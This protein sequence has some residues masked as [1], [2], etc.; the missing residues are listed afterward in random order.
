[1]TIEDPIE[2]K[3]NGINQMQVNLKAG[4]DFAKGLRAIL[5]QDP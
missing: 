1:M 5:R 2:M 4:M 3:I